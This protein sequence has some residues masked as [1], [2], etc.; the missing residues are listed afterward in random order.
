M[1]LFFL[2][3]PQHKPLFIIITVMI[4]SDVVFSAYKKL[5]HYF[6]YDNTSLFVREKLATFEKSVLD[7]VRQNNSS[8]KEGVYEQFISIVSSD[9]WIKKIESNNFITYR[10]T[11]KSFKVK[12]RDFLTNKKENGMLNLE[13]VNIIADIDINLHIISI[14]W[15]MYAGKYLN[16]FIPDNNYAYKLELNEDDKVE[17]IR[18]GL[19]LY[20]PY[21]IQYQDWRDKAIN[22]AEQILNERKNATILSL[23]IK[24]YFYSVKIDLIQIKDKILG[25]INELK[26]N[27]KDADEVL[28]YTEEEQAIDFLSN[29]LHDI[30][31]VY[32]K[33]VLSIA[34]KLESLIEK[35]STNTMLPI[36]LMSSGLL[37]NYYLAS[38]DEAVKDILNPA[39]YGRYVDDML[40]VFSE[41]E[42]KEDAISTVNTFINKYFVKRELLTIENDESLSDFFYKEPERPTEYTEVKVK[43]KIIDGKIINEKLQE[44]YI[45]G[46]GR[47]VF[48][49]NNYESL[50]IQGEKIVLQHFDKYESRAVINK[51]KKNLKDNRSEF[52]FLPDEDKIDTDFDEAAFSMYYVDSVNKLRSIKEFS[53][54]KYGASKYLANKIF[55]KSYSDEITDKSTTDQIL[56]FFKGLVG[57]SFYTLWEKVCTYFVVTDCPKGIV[58]FYRQIQRSIRKIDYQTIELAQS[59][60]VTSQMPHDLVKYLKISIATP[61]AL[62]PD[63]DFGDFIDQR[64][65]DFFKECRDLAIIIRG[66]NMLRHSLI[67]IPAIN[68]TAYGNEKEGRYLNLLKFNLNTLV[69]IWKPATSFPTDFLEVD[70]TLA[71]FS[72]RYVH[73]HEL[74]I[75]HIYKTILQIEDA[76]SL[77]KKEEK[78]AKLDES[79]AEVVNN[80]KETESDIS[81]DLINNI[82]NAAFKDYYIIN[83]NW[84]IQKIDEEKLKKKYF[85]IT[86]APQGNGSTKY[87][88]IDVYETL[89]SK[90]V[91]KRISLA[92]IKVEEKN[93]V[94]SIRDKPNTS[95]SRR[96]A[97]FNLINMVDAEKSDLFVLPEVSVPFSWVKLLAFQSSKRDFGIIAGLEHWINHKKFAFNFMVT[98]LPIVIDN[99]RT[100]LIKIRLKN[101]YSHEEK[102]ILK[103]HR[104]LIPQATLPKYPKSYDLFHWRKTYFSVYNCFELADIADRGLM[105]AKTDFIVASEY[106]QDLSYFSD[107]AGSWARD[108]H[109][110]F[111]QV[112]SSHFGDS[113]ITQPAKSYAKDLVQIR[114]GLNETILVGNL[115]IDQLREFQLVEYN[116]QKDMIIKGKTV[117]KPTPPDFDIKEVEKRIENKKLNTK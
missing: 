39:Y 34:P 41:A 14:L 111:I 6:Y 114:G 97:L 54:D 33:K 72:P 27:T 105:K 17:E 99:Y 87:F 5:K 60:L 31:S 36:G 57:L 47:I 107:I 95:K 16:I 66:T 38:F 24:N 7:S 109:S 32:Y 100:C 40:F 73:F 86:P 93:I 91:N 82:P 84:R 90:T 104:L 85:Q 22:K 76:D 13:R 55:A 63:I 96:Q 88:N 19:K 4:S 58:K 8:I 53:E 83:Y 89:E 49:I 113:R 28:R 80:S 52:R 59:D 48:K 25:K 45:K 26:K 51:F 67:D 102:E 44:E 103:G 56:T 74:N 75:L 94:N 21:F 92:N 2:N 112:N 42:I 62:N 3:T 65:K 46:S 81:L 110:Y 116:L 20:K 117:L 29:K 23:D 101:H 71:L 15:I 18:D 9:N 68:F 11:P 37:G 30:H 1:Y 43:E 98:V 106:N 78:P 77:Q 64:E 10:I 50:R 108:I 61:L 12:H 115:E 79:K 70:Q 35:N 69:D